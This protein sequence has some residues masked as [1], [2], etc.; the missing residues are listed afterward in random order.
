MQLLYSLPDFR[1]IVFTQKVHPSK[2]PI[3]QL[4]RAIFEQLADI[5]AKDSTNLVKLIELLKRY[6]RRL[7]FTA[8][9]AKYNNLYQQ[10]AQEFLTDLIETLNEELSEGTG[11]NSPVRMIETTDS[12]DLYAKYL[13]WKKYYFQKTNNSL[14]S[15][16]FFTHILDV[17]KC[18]SCKTSKYSFSYFSALPLEISESVIKSAP[19]EDY[20]MPLQRSVSLNSD[21]FTL[22]DLIRKYFQPEIIEGYKCNFCDKTT[23]I[24]KEQY[25]I[26]SPKILLV[27]FKRFN[28]LE[29]VP[30]KLNTKIVMNDFMFIDKM[31]QNSEESGAYDL[32]A[33]I[34][35]YGAINSGHYI[36]SLRKENHWVAISDDRAAAEDLYRMSTTGSSEVYLCAFSKHIGL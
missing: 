17:L 13:E 19:D 4:L 26:H 9:K 2:A 30:R 14:I 25:I 29:E 34:K 33:F 7:D 16:L 1:K 6:L 35:H 36:A 15:D 8:G 10:D 3:L 27:Y 23:S 11:D 5:K 32:M 12:K 28:M 21:Y 20:S 22:D 31:T 24:Q 18:N